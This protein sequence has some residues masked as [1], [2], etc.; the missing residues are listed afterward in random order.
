MRVRADQ[1]FQISRYHNRKNDLLIALGR[2][3]EANVHRQERNAFRLDNAI[4][5]DDD[6]PREVDSLGM[7]IA[8]AHEKALL[9]GD[10]REFDSLVSRMLDLLEETGGIP[11]D[12]DP[13]AGSAFQFASLGKI[14]LAKEWVQ[15][16]ED[17]HRRTE[18]EMSARGKMVS[19]YVD[20]LDGGNI[21]AAI[22]AI[23]DG[24]EEI[25][26]DRCWGPELGQL[27]ELKHDTDGAVAAYERY[28]NTRSLSALGADEGTFALA[29]FRLGALYEEKG[30]LDQAITYYSK[31]A[32]RWKD[33]DAVLQPQVAEARRR[34]EA[35]LD[36]KARE[37]G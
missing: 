5:T 1:P 9:T 33:A 26:C 27:Y 29:Q 21:D 30:D 14:D 12:R 3:E 8:W 24:I 18:D 36:R 11:D 4:R 37:D 22:A 16:H 6:F 31:M 34:I 28:V 32:E 15:K 2:M 23:R 25:G 35:L 7:A 17:Y 10:T 19:A 13:Y 20:A